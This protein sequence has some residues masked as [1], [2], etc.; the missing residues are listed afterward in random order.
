MWT[1]S[2]ICPTDNSTYSMNRTNILWLFHQWLLQIT[3]TSHQTVSARE[4]SYTCSDKNNRSAFVLYTSVC[5]WLEACHCWLLPN[6]RHPSRIH[7]LITF[8]LPLSSLDSLLFFPFFLAICLATAAPSI[9]VLL[10]CIPLIPAGFL[11]LEEATKTPP[12]SPTHVCHM[13]LEKLL[14]CSGSNQ[15]LV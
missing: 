1:S 10:D 2:L 11:W 13:W 9:T 4:N 6:C 15:T 12:W 8:S 7:S 3:F 14:Y 5:S